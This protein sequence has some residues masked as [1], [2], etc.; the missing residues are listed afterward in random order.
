ML[1]RLV[2]KGALAVK[3]ADGPNVYTARARREECVKAETRSFAARVFAGDAASLLLHYVDDARL[4]RSELGE[5][6]RRLERKLEEAEG[7]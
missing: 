4:S 5:L 1:A 2:R 6:K 7:E 3:P